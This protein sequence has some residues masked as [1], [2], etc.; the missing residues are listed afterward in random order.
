ML[1]KKREMHDF[2][3]EPLRRLLPHI[4]SNLNLL[5]TR[6]RVIYRNI[7]TPSFATQRK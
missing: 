2:L 6:A 1:E 5:F 7:H 3:N 4:V